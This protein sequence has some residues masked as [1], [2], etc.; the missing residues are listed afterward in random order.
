MDE[1]AESNASDKWEPIQIVLEKWD[2]LLTH[3]RCLATLRSLPGADGQ[4]ISELV[5]TGFGFYR[6]KIGRWAAVFSP[7]PATL[8]AALKEEVTPTAVEKGNL[9]IQF[10]FL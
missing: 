6:E 3:L 8:L 9:A 7:K 4:S 1:S 5:G 2:V 10:V